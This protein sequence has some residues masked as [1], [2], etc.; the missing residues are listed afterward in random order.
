[1]EDRFVSEVDAARGISLWRSNKDMNENDK[2]KK[3]EKKE[4]KK[5]TKNDVQN[6][7]N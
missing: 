5:Q 6:E 3:K 1:V 2:K 4:K 7:A